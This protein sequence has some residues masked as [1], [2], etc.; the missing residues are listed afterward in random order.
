VCALLAV[1][2]IRALAGPEEQARI[3]GFRVAKDLRAAD[4]DLSQ[5][6]DGLRRGRRFA[7]PERL[8]EDPDI[9]HEHAEAGE[10]E[11][12][13]ELA[14]RDVALLGRVDAELLAPE[15]QASCSHM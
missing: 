13:P 9:A 12:L 14:A 3:G 6:G 2:D 1:G 7:P 8:D 15:H 5:P 10:D 4:R 11:E